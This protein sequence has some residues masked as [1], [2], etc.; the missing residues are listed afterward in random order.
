MRYP[1]L[2]INRHALPGQTFI[3]GDLPPSA[4][5]SLVA[6][7]LG[8]SEVDGAWEQSETPASSPVCTFSP[9]AIDEWVRI[10]RQLNDGPTPADLFDSRVFYATPAG[11]VPVGCIVE[12]VWLI[13]HGLAELYADGRLD[14]AQ[15]D[16]RPPT[17]S[18]L[19]E[20]ARFLGRLG[21]EDGA[22]LFLGAVNCVQLQETVPPERRPAFIELAVRVQG[23]SATVIGASGYSSPV[24]AYVPVELRG[25]TD[26]S[27]L[28][29]TRW[30]VRQE[31]CPLPPDKLVAG[32][33]AGPWHATT[34]R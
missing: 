32:I 25:R 24:G 29:A 27:K 8:V 9:V 33:T 13:H 16:P 6:Q 22:T 2:V 11:D 1:D 31:G 17:A 23:T 15:G 4:I 10:L 3:P 20:A 34:F 12:E 5:R 19:Y 28:R 30:A 26:L 14:Y 7:A 21:A 18:Q